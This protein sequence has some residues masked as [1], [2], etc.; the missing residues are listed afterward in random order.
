MLK[1]FA[2]VML[3]IASASTVLAGSPPPN[4]APK[5]AEALELPMLV[6]V[7]RALNEKYPACEGR[8]QAFSRGLTCDLDSP[9]RLRVYWDGRVRTIRRNIWSGEVVLRSQLWE[10]VIAGE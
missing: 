5:L 4:Y 6:Q 7:L 3:I 10:G 9:V 8:W 1:F 2:G